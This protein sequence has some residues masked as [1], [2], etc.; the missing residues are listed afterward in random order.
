MIK[1]ILD[2]EKIADSTD[3][4][5]QDDIQSIL[6]GLFGEVGSIMAALKKL[7][8][9][10]TDFS[11][12]KEAVVEEL[13]DAFWYFTALTKRYELSVSDVISD[14]VKNTE[15]SHLLQTNDDLQLP[16]AQALESPTSTEDIS[17]ALIKLGQATS[18]ILDIEDADKAKRHQILGAF[19]V[20]FFE[21]TV[22]DNISFERILNFNS[23]KIKE[24]FI[25]PN[26]SDLPDFDDNIP[27]KEQFPREFKIKIKEFEDGKVYIKKDGVLLGD[28]LT[29]NIRVED[30][31]RFHDVLHFAHI[32][33]LHWSPTMRG[34]FKCKRKSNP[35]FD[36]NE[37]G[38]RGIVI[39]EGLAA[40]VFSKAKELDDF[41]GQ[42]KVSI[43]ILK[44]IK[45]FVKGYEVAQCPPI[46]WQKAIL[47]GYCV[48]RQ[49]KKNKSGI[50]VGNRDK[51]TLEYLPLDKWDD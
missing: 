42:K 28:P 10:G 45:D 47:N 48:F 19:V 44:I 18:S 12:Y 24:F 17:K 30:F 16:T 34:F 38:G 43:D 41:K 46:L 33:I 7:K 20:A 35:D 4:F 6:L 1:L 11:I 23:K 50:I 9:D 37:D 39:E 2:Y 29:D 32:A 14:S 25:L 31:F 40:W 21:V 27:E 49:V 22:Q 36:E 8:R 26:Y 5:A 15:N 13:G 3:R 51:R